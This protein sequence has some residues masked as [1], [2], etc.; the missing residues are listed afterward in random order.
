LPTDVTALAD[1]LLEVFDRYLPLLPFFV[2]WLLR[3]V[4]QANQ[5]DSFVVVKAKEI[6]IS[7]RGAT[8]PVRPGR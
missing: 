5:L 6:S 8:H 1:P 3:H 4:A 7:L 2:N